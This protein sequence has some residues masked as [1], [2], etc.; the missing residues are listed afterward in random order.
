MRRL[1][2]G[3]INLRVTSMEWLQTEM[4]KE[5]LEPQSNPKLGLRL[6]LL[7]SA[8]RMTEEL[9]KYKTEQELDNNG[10]KFWWSPQSV[11]GQ[12]RLVMRFNAKTIEGSATYVDNT[13][14]AVKDGIKKLR[15][16][17]ERTTDAQWAPEEARLKKK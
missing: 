7:A 10:V 2:A 16:V 14:D 8:D 11:N 4:R 6:R 9:G 12:R 15:N 13:L 5:G 17:I 3:I 1:F